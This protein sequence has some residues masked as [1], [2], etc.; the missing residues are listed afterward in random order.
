MLRLLSDLP[1]NVV[2]LEAV[3]RVEAKDYRD[4]LEP[5][6]ASALGSGE[7]LRLLYVLG[8]EFDG[9]TVGAGWEDTKVGLGHWDSWDRIA[10]VTDREW[11]AHA[12]KAVAWML[13]GQV[14]VF[15]VS[16]RD[17]AT[18]WVTE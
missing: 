18:A 11:I 16:E 13:P 12:V 4:V 14:R 17:E 2:G 5:A 10:V 8:A 3:G 15:S 9:L 7:K 1:P 6:V